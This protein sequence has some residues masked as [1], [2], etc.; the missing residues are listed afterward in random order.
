V[1][2]RG[3]RLGFGGL[4]RVSAV[5]SVLRAERTQSGAERRACYKVHGLQPAGGARTQARADP[6][7]LLRVRVAPQAYP[8]ARSLRPVRPVLSIAAWHCGGFSQLRSCANQQR[9]PQA[10]NVAAELQRL[11]RLPQTAHPAMRTYGVTCVG[12]TYRL[13]GTFEGK[14]GFAWV[15]RAFTE[16]T[17]QFAAAAASQA[18]FPHGMAH[19][20][21]FLGTAHGMAGWSQVHGHDRHGRNRLFHFG[22]AAH[23]SCVR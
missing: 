16:Y 22:P 1:H 11:R 17:A 14:T 4:C 19:A 9:Q 23:S 10:T 3:I 15:S 6:S 7:A 21:G 8:R 12:F 13:C 18:A 2:T 5:L 20:D